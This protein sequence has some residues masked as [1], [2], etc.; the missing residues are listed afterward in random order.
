MQPDGSIDER[1]TILHATASWRPNNDMMVFATFS[2]GYR[3]ATL[4]RNAGQFANTQT[5]IFE[6]YAVPTVALTDRLFNY[7]LGMKGD[8]AD[9][10]LRV[11]A[12]AYRW[13]IED[14]QLSRYDPVNVAFNYFIENVGDAEARGLDV[15]AQWLATNTLTIGTTFA[16]LDTELASA[17]PQLAGVAVPAGADLPLAPTFSGNLRFRYDW[18]VPWKA[19]VWC[20]ASVVYRGESLAGMIGNAEYMDDT[21]FHQTGL[22]SGLE[23]HDEGGTFGNIPIPANAPGGRR[24]PRNTRFVNP[25]ATTVHLSFGFEKDDWQAELFVRN[26]TDENAA[27][28]QTGGRYTP[29]VSLQRPRSVGLRL[30][31]RG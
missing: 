20:A 29:V 27:I 12:T 16:L 3:P 23:M 2:E 31:Y 14:L 18:P 22:R 19:K 15:D 1:D 11:N 25:A 26:A 13:A 8:F 10:L 28:V 5:G 21:L 9:G 7:E 17:S 4:N 24:L 30:S 6:G